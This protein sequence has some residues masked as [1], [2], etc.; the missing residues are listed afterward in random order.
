MAGQG[1]H[2]LLCCP[3]RGGQANDPKRALWFS[4][5]SERL[6][7]VGDAV[8]PEREKEIR[9]AHEEMPSPLSTELFAE[10]DDLREALVRHR[11]ALSDYERTR[12]N[13]S[14]VDTA[15]AV[16]REINRVLNSN[17]DKLSQER[18]QLRARLEAVM[19]WVGCC[20]FDP[21]KIQEM[22]LLRE[23]A[24]DSLVEIPPRT[25]RRDP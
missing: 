4:H 7:S 5:G 23:L 17:C 13:L 20:P 21:A 19:P 9:T 10:I 2:I 12:H 24:E 6:P 16:S 25:A 22:S 8:T 18:D 11:D 3:L 14:L 15:L 1:A